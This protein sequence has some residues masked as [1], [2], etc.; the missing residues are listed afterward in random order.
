MDKSP[1]PT[2]SN[3]K[4][5]LLSLGCA[6][7][8]ML[9]GAVYKYF[10]PKRVAVMDDG[11]Y[12]HEDKD[13]VQGAGDMELMVHVSGKFYQFQL[14]D[15]NIQSQQLMKDGR[16]R[17]TLYKKNG[18]IIVSYKNDEGEWVV[19]KEESTAPSYITKCVKDKDGKLVERPDLL[20]NEEKSEN[21]RFMNSVGD[22]LTQNQSDEKKLEN[23]RFMESIGNIFTQDPSDKELIE[24]IETM[25]S[26]CE[27]DEMP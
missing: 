23:E 14:P 22:I 7:L 13:M 26:D 4:Y 11:D 27:D 1:V 24:K 18:S 9:A 20:S 10:T 25:S 8:G 21:E 17:Q 16:W 12:P 6:G 5:L 19:S 15:G 3:S 2:S